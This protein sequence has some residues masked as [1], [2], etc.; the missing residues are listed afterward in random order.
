MNGLKFA[1]G[2]IAVLWAVFLLDYIVPINFNEYGMVPRTSSG[3]IGI[4]TM[5]FLHANWQ[6][7]IGN[8]LPLLV[9]LILLAAGYPQRK[10]QITVWLMIGTGILLWACGRT[11]MHLGASGL[12]YAL[13]SFLFVFSIREKRLWPFLISLLI[14]VVNWSSIISGILG[15]DPRISWDGHLLGAI[16][17]IVIALLDTPINQKE[18]I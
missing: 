5:H 9:L 18:I 15:S 1:F 10:I 8:S 11:A 14:L 17:G 12:V 13:I 2:F 16:A 4:F 7:L 6:H 3:T